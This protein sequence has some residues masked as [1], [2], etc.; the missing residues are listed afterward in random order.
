MGRRQR[1]SPFCFRKNNFAYVCI[2]ALTSLY[3]QSL[4]AQESASGQDAAK[5]D[6]FESKIRP[7]LIEHCYECHATDSA[8]I[9][10]NLLLD[11]K[12]GMV[13]GGDLGRTL[14][15]GNPEKSLI[16]SALKH[17]DL[18]MP[19][20]GK[21]DP[22]IVRD[23]EQ[24][25]RDGAVDPRLD[26]K[27]VRKSV[28]DIEAGKKFWSLL[29]IQSPKLDPSSSMTPID[30][31]MS[32][33]IQSKFPQA[34]KPLFHEA[35]RADLLVRIY[36]DLIGLP[37]PPQLQ[38]DFLAGKT[39]YEQV[40]DR[41]LASKHFGERFGRH[42]LDVARYADSS[43]GGRILM[44]PD[45]WRYRDYVVRSFNRDKGFDRFVV[46]QLAGDLLPAS[47]LEQKSDQLT[48]L[49]FLMLG[50]HNFEL[51]DKELLRME[52]VDEQ[53]NVFGR[54]F[55]GL[56][57][58]CARCHD[59]KFD[60]IPT[61]DYYALAG[62]FR[63]TKSLLPGNVSQFVTTN[64][65]LPP[66]TEQKLETFNQ[67]K[68][69]AQA[70]VDELKKKLV[71][72]Q[73]N[74]IK[75]D[76][77]NL[78]SFAGQIIDEEQATRVG[79]WTHSQSVKPFVHKGYHHSLDPAAAM[80]FEFIVAAK[81]QYSLRAAYTASSNRTDGGNYEVLING[82]K[83]QSFQIN[84]RKRPPIDN[85]FAKLRDLDLKKGDRLTVTLKTGTGGT[86][87]ADAIHLLPLGLKNSPDELTRRKERNRRVQQLK[88][89]LDRAQKIL[90]KFK[91]PPAVMEKVMSVRD[92]SKPE[93]FFVCI[94]G[95]VHSLGEKVERRALQV[96][97]NLNAFSNLQQ[98]G[99]LELAQWIVDRKNPLT[100]R[101][102]ANR[103]WYWLL[104][105]GIVDTPDNLG[106]MGQRPS[107]P[108]LLDYLA[109]RLVQRGWSTK[110]LIR[111]IVMS[112]TYRQRAATGQS[113]DPDGRLYLSLPRKRLDAEAIRDR[114]LSFSG[115]LDTAFGGPA[116]KPGTRKEFGYKY[117]SPRRSLYLP[118]F[119]NTMNE[120]F[121]VFDFPNPNLVAGKRITSILPTQALYLMNSRFV[122]EQSRFAASRILAHARD[123]FEKQLN[124]AYQISVSRLPTPAER[125]VAKKFFAASQS[126]PG[127]EE[128]KIEETWAQF[129]QILISSLDFR[130]LK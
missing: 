70:R 100:A 61:T 41:L 71:L 8:D 32:R 106:T 77:Q 64:L 17:D 92:E 68:K 83:K 56:T 26:G 69:A 113:K 73:K 31:L 6:F 19:P 93:D 90:A 127:L 13:V 94:R 112:Q 14:I 62:I 103:V 117:D 128:K 87:I 59:H 108:E 118:V 2:F 105:T 123:D 30:Q 101:V 89:E 111:E 126:K 76:A 53:I 54:A 84:Q 98:S 15:P 104:G 81:G 43:G 22:A 55:L 102:Y 58:S 57:L 130:Y 39:T 115:Q 46:E 60:P 24:W 107:H 50:P 91:K 20:D 7:L 12:K 65:P 78:K 16:I 75:F 42:W 10:G 25:I 29:P 80:K 95:D 51:Q 35:A 27:T 120:L 85:H 125:I 33:R 109:S 110:S 114:I 121:E 82:A 38:R 40:V 34:D 28:I 11:S 72:T 116:I 67:Q 45:A 88:M 23:F 4:L 21:L 47:T 119:R 66:E 124:Y 44:F 37:P 49:G 96:I 48:A 99:R 52:V 129:C 5:L 86:T 122:G 18:E 9:G 36:F 3:I 79:D 1:N 97:G 63:S 74:V